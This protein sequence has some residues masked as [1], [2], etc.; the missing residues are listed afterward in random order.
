MT[1]NH[2]SNAIKIPTKSLINTRVAH[3]AKWLILCTSAALVACAGM[4]AAPPEEV[5]KQRVNERWKTL[6]SSDF[7]R[8][9]SY[10]APSFRAL[11]SQDVYRSRIGGAVNWVAGEVATVQCPEAIKCIARVRIDYKP[12]LR[13]RPG[14][15]FS[16]YADETWV[17]E[18]G[19]WWAFEPLRA[20]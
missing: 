2:T 8:S 20:N 10:T 3:V 1:M 4:T 7:A 18:N 13:G 12:L 6:V 9:Y 17:L 5:V 11:I 14:D 19:Q 15:T 16:T